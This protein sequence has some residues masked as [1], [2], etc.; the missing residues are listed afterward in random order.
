MLAI[1]RHPS[2]GSRPRAPAARARC[3]SARSPTPASAPTRRLVR[4]CRGPGP[5]VPVSISA[6]RADRPPG[7]AI[8]S[9]PPCASSSVKTAIRSPLRVFSCR[10]AAMMPPMLVSGSI[11]LRP[12]GP[13]ASPRDAADRR[14]GQLAGRPRAE[15]LQR[16]RRSDRPDGRSS[17]ARASPSRRRAARSRSTA[18]RPAAAAPTGPCRGRPRSVVIV[19]ARRTAAPALRLGRAARARRARTPRRRPP[20]A[21]AGAPTVG[22]DSSARHRPA[23]ANRTRRP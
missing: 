14:V 21:A 5:C 16:R 1:G 20:A 2:A 18:W 11:G 15:L 8:T 17:T 22:S 3:R 19:E 6:A 23:R 10:Q 12:P 13:Q 9:T 7:N 4:A